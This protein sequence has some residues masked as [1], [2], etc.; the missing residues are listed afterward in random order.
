VGAPCSHIPTARYLRDLL[1]AVPTRGTKFRS[2]KL[3]S[4]RE[5]ERLFI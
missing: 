5:G 2:L 1:G 4:S 3:L